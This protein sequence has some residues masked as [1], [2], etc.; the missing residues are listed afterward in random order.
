MWANQ[1]VDEDAHGAGV[2]LVPREQNHGG[3]DDGAGGSGGDGS[4]E[5]AGKQGRSREERRAAVEEKA[6]AA[7]GVRAA[8]AAAGDERGEGQ[9]VGPGGYC[10]PRHRVPSHW[11]DEGSKCVSNTV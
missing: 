3:G 6:S 5:G 2:S 1:L 9:E 11:K 8:A 4:G 7:G 10:S